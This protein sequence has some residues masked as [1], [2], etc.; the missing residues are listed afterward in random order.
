MKNFLDGMM[1]NNKKGNDK[2]KKMIRTLLIMSLVVI[3]GWFVYSAGEM[4]AYLTYNK[5]KSSGFIEYSN[6]I[7][8]LNKNPK[9]K[10]V[11]VIRPNRKAYFKFGSDTIY[12]EVKGFNKNINLK[13]FKDMQKD[14]NL[15]MSGK[16]NIAIESIIPNHESLV[17][18]SW[19]YT[20]GG[21]FGALM[22][23][24]LPIG[25]IIFLVMMMKSSGA[26]ILGE[27][28]FTSNRE[29][30]IKTKL[31]D[32]A[33]MEEVKN[34]VLE[35]I[36]FLKNPKKYESM[37]I[38]VPRGVLLYG[39]P[40]NGKTLLAKAI[41]GESEVPFISQSGSSFIEL[42]AGQGA[43][44]VRM[45]F[46]EAKMLA[47]KYGGCVL[48]ID[49]IDAIGK[50]RSGAVLGH[51][52]AEQTINELLTQLDGFTGKDNIVIIGA[53]NMLEV[54]DDALVRTGRFDRKIFIPSP[55]TYARE[56]ILKLHLTNKNLAPDINVQKL[57]E[58]SPG[59]SGSDL[60]NWINEATFQAIREERE[61]I[62]MSDF[63]NARER[64]LV[65][66]ENKGIK[67]NEI[68]RKTTAYHESGHAVVRLIELGEVDR[69]TIKPMGQ[70]LGVTFSTPPDRVLLTKEMIDTEIKVLLGGRVA[71]EIF[72]K[73][74]SNGASNDLE[75]ASKL[76]YTAI[77]KFGLSEK[78]GEYLPQTEKCLGEADELAQ[79][80][81]SYLR[82]MVKKILTEHSALV[83]EIAEILIEKDVVDSE[84]IKEL[85]KK[86]HEG[87][88]HV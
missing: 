68:E 73:Q 62:T 60:E 34:E 78:F 53:T 86:H 70:A 36:H 79:Q 12:K 72:I 18:N 63:N 77:T 3:V 15:K 87:L 64:I 7:S 58:L 41:A 51:S 13:D 81:M 67:M 6:F 42:F 59:F 25:L 69:I 71:E 29:I 82:G 39:N 2:I 66:P 75:R 45:F 43:R 57:A 49:E 1:N 21:F 46:K 35:V 44:S 50:K 8:E 40:G 85:L 80:E 65:G 74:I 11:F 4:D 83:I 20:V 76:A 26:G 32:V 37:N 23:I 27:K 54:L 61:V 17:V 10:G 33:G 16:I 19:L 5:F 56:D 48:F 52:E 55:G 24:F 9:L 30:N 47:H 31:S 38:H 22:R 28:K 14:K 88:Q 84:E